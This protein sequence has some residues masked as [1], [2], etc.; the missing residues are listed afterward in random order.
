MRRTDGGGKKQGRVCAERVF[1]VGAWR[2]THFGRAPGLDRPPPPPWQPLL[3][4][5]G[6]DGPPLS[7]SVVLTTAA[8]D[9]AV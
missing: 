2:S 7:G 5:V 1:C 9:A 8:L 4:W 6:Q 3:R